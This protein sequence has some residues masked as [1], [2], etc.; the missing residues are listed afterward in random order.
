MQT[1]PIS[2][3]HVYRQ[4]L[5]Q[6]LKAKVLHEARQAAAKALDITF[7]RPTESHISVASGYGHNTN[8]P[9][10]TLSIAN[11][12]ETAN[13]TVQLRAEIAQQI[14]HDILDAADAAIS[15][16]FLVGWL[17]T[18]MDVTE[19]QAASLLNDFRAYRE[20]RGKDRE[21]V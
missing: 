17:S 5:Q 6:V 14:A 8:E 7:D 16:A 12:A 11:P 1:D 18:G 3:A 10:V 2:A 13:P 4:A 20:S 15:D 21:E 19:R 9:F